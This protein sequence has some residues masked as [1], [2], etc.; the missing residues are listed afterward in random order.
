MEPKFRKRADGTVILNDSHEADR[1]KKSAKPWSRPLPPDKVLELAKQAAVQQ[2]LDPEDEVCVLGLH[3]LQFRFFRGQTFRWVLE[4]ALGFGGYLVASMIRESERGEV[5]DA[6]ANK[7]NK[8]AFRRYMEMFPEGRGAISI[9]LQRA[10]STQSS[11]STSHVGSA[12]ASATASTSWSPAPPVPPT[13]RSAS[14]V[15]SASGFPSTKRVPVTSLRGLLVGKSLSQRSLDM[16]VRRLVSSSANRFQPTIPAVPARGSSEHVCPSVPAAVP[17]ELETGAIDDRDLV[18]AAEHAEEAIAAQNRV[19][20]PAGWIP[21]LPVL[22]QQWISKALFKW[23]RTGQPELDFT[24]VDRMWWHTPN[25]SLVPTGIP[26]MERYF[27]HSLFIWMPRK[28][29]R[30]RLLCPHED[31]GKEEL[32]SA[33]LHQRVRQVVGVSGTYFMVAEYLACKGCKRKV[34]SWTCNIIRQLDIGHRVHFPCLLTSKLGCDMQVVRQMRQRGLGNSCSQLRKQCFVGSHGPAQWPDC[35][36]LVEAIFIQLCMAI[37]GRKKSPEGSQSRW[38]QIIHAYSNLRQCIINNARVMADTTIQLPEV[39]TAT[40][41]QWYN[42]RSRSQETEVLQQAIPCPEAPI[43]GPVRQQSTPQKEALSVVVVV[44]NPHVFSLPSNTAGTARLKRR[45]TFGEI[46]QPAA[47]FAPLQRPSASATATL[48]S[49]QRPSASATATL[50]SVQRPSA[51]ATLS[52]MQRPSASAT[53]SSMQHPSASA[54]LSSMLHPS[55]TA[56]QGPSQA[57]ANPASQSCSFNSTSFRYTIQ[58][59]MEQKEENG[60]GRGG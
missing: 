48:S 39:N 58:H 57:K 56:T 24:R 3:T 54:T 11:S 47:T 16:S 34:I 42:K 35:N 8:E 1:V 28:L 12:S 14:A 51:S 52:S 25:P 20:L 7:A 2:G 44:D 59:T 4:N 37:T 60:E 13:S 38:T 30:V 10:L 36:R 41:A 32:T 53:L 18:M 43:A 45:L 31:C 26:P 50:A 23:S 33:G 49:V 5:K 17:C 6:L 21:A 40:L 29:W 22:D 55:T 27:G 9:K 19:C 15:P 46:D